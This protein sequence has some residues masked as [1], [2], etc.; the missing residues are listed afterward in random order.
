M[1]KFENT[2]LTSHFSLYEMCRVDKYG[3]VNSPS[4]F[5][6]D[7]LYQLCLFLEQL[8]SQL[9]CAVIVTSGFRNVSVNNSVGGVPHSD[10]LYGLAAD[11]RVKGSTPTKLCNLIRSIPLL[12]GQV[13]QVIIYPTFLHVSINRYKHK[14]KYLIKKGSRYEIYKS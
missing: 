6:K 2:F 9:G 8:R 13:G 12:N 5:V 1:E 10:H 14:S 4:S 3:F 11:I 7:N